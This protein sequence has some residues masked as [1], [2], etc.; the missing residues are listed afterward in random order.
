MDKWCETPETKVGGP[1]SGDNKTNVRP[2][3]M[4]LLIGKFGLQQ[5]ASND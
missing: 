2:I 4:N 5:P 1:F 3:F